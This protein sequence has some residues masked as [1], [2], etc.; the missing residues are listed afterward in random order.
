MTAKTTKTIKSLQ[1]EQITPKGM[2]G[3]GT[4]DG[5]RPRRS[6]RCHRADTHRGAGRWGS[7]A[8]MGRNSVRG[9]RGG[10]VPVEGAVE[11]PQL[12]LDA[13]AQ[14]LGEQDPKTHKPPP[15]GGGEFSLVASLRGGA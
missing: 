9:E 12:C 14:G 15:Q 5:Q 6:P 1:N 10:F 4:G 7:L 11:D 13:P 2:T 8:G 3:E